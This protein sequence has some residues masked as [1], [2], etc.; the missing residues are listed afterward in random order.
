MQVSFGGALTSQGFQLIVGLLWIARTTPASM[1]SFSSTATPDVQL[2]TSLSPAGRLS[3]LETSYL[4]PG[5]LGTEDEQ[6]AS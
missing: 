5:A 4:A 3:A 2:V 6:S 1:V